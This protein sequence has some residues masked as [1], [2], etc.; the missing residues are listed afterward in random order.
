MA[1]SKFRHNSVESVPGTPLQ[2]AK[3]F[4]RVV[5]A[6]AGIAGPATLLGI[7]V[8]ILHQRITFMIDL[9]I[10][11]AAI[12]LVVGGL[13]GLVMPIL[14]VPSGPGAMAHQRGQSGAR[15]WG[16]PWGLLPG[17]RS[18]LRCWACICWLDLFSIYRQVPTGAT[19]PHPVMYRKQ[20]L[21]VTQNAPPLSRCLLHWVRRWRVIRSR[22]ATFRCLPRR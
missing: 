2:V 12:M 18:E 1:P 13:I 4:A 6:S 3:H 7:S 16:W 14:P 19:S 10:W 21:M 8:L 20:L 15:R 11:L 5:N 9:L 22:A 17:W